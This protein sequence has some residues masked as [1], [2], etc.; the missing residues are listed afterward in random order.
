[1]AIRVRDEEL[2]FPFIDVLV[3][4]STICTSS[5]PSDV[6]TN[7][8]I[9]IWVDNS[10]FNL[11]KQSSFGLSTVSS[12]SRATIRTTSQPPTQASSTPAVKRDQ[13]PSPCPPCTTAA[14]RPPPPTP[15]TSSTPAEPRLK[16]NMYTKHANVYNIFW[17]LSRSPLGP[18]ITRASYCADWLFQVYEA[19]DRA[20]NEPGYGLG[21]I[22]IDDF[23]KRVCP[24]QPGSAAPASAETPGPAPSGSADGQQEAGVTYHYLYAGSTYFGLQLLYKWLNAAVTGMSSFRG[25]IQLIF[26][27]PNGAPNWAG[28][29]GVCFNMVLSFVPHFMP[30]MLIELLPRRWKSGLINSGSC[31]AQF[32][33]LLISL[34]RYWI[35]TLLSFIFV[36][37]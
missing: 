8:S 9:H 24:H 3:A 18:G 26:G 12:G 16:L 6:S 30:R 17:S 14:P 11:L 1:M 32:A 37:I 34:I 19:D 36:V 7:Y 15:T 33:L 23:V 27:A 29:R 21:K 35:F 20:A 10:L 28:Y 4:T 5:L 13:T 2:I 31:V 22:V 25:A